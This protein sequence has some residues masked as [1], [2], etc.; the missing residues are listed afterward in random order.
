MAG[1]IIGGKILRAMVAALLALLASA[2][3]VPLD[4]ADTVRD[5]GT[6][7]DIGRGA[8][9]MGE[10]K[11]LFD[12]LHPRWSWHAVLSGDSWRVW[13]QGDASDNFI[14]E[15]E[16]YVAKRD[17]KPSDCTIFVG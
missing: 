16:V 17:G 12:R 2:C 3:T 7:I 13:R 11:V 15:L 14:P 5:S 1:P 8:C 10:D 9:R 4:P 6:A